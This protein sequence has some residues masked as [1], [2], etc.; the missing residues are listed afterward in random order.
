MKEA[1]PKDIHSLLQKMCGKD[2]TR[3][4]YCWMKAIFGDT[5]LEGMNQDLLNKIY[6]CLISKNTGKVCLVHGKAHDNKFK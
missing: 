5:R 1:T 2:R 6:S 4:G 3:R